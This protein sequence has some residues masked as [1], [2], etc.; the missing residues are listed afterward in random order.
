MKHSLACRFRRLSKR[1]SRIHPLSL[2]ST[3]SS[4]SGFRR[5][6]PRSVSRVEKL[7]FSLRARARSLLA[8][9]ASVA[10]EAAGPCCKGASLALATH[11]RAARVVAAAP[12]QRRALAALLPARRV[13]APRFSARIPASECRRYTPPIAAVANRR[14]GGSAPEGRPDTAARPPRDSP[15]DPSPPSTSDA[16]PDEIVEA[17]DRLGVPKVSITRGMAKAR[18][19]Y[20]SPRTLPS[21]RRSIMAPDHDLAAPFSCS[22]FDRAAPSC[23]R[24]RSRRSTVAAPGLVTRWP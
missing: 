19:C 18:H 10:M 3:S 20:M 5:A 22:Y 14:R 1:T 12:Q 11:D 16:G 23:S 24:T 13:S 7:T 9:L 8:Q 21:Y 6:L 4:I 17:A 15:S 2:L